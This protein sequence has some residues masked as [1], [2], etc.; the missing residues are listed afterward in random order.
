[1]KVSLI[2]KDKIVSIIL[3]LQIH[4]NYWIV[5][6]TKEGK[7]RNFINIV[8][9]G[10][11]WR[12]LSNYEINIYQNNEY[13]EYVDLT[14]NT[15]YLVKINGEEDALIYC[16]KVYEDR[17]AQLSLKHEADIII[18]SKENANICCNIPQILSEHA[19]LS[20]KN[21][22]WII[23]EINKDGYIYVNNVRVSNCKL[24]NGDII[25]IMGLK[26]IVIKNNIIINNIDKIKVDGNLFSEYRYQKQNVREAKETDELITLYKDSDYFFK[27]PRFRNNP[28]RIT[29]KVDSPP[30]KEKEE[31]TPIMYIIG[32]ML[33]MGMTSMVTAFTSINSVISNGRS[34]N[35]ALPSILIS[36]SMLMTMILWPILTRRY[37]K[38]ERKKK[39]KERRQKY[40][41]YIE[42][43][44]LEVRNAIAT[45][46]TA[47][48][49]SFP[50]LEEHK[51]TILFK[52]SNLWEKER[53]QEDFLRLRIGTGTEPAK[54]DISYPEEH[55][56]MDEDDLTGIINNLVSESKDLVNVPITV[57]FAE[58]YISALIGDS[59]VIEKIAKGLILQLITYHSYDDLKIVF[60][61]KEDKKE[62]WDFARVLPHCWNEDKTM[63]YYATNVDEMKQISSVLKNQFQSRMYKDGNG[64]IKNFDYKSYKPY[65]FIITDDFMNARD[66][67]IVKDVLSQKINVGFSLFILNDK[68]TNLPN[69][70]MNF[71]CI[72]H[73]NKSVIFEDELVTDKQKKFNVDIVEDLDLTECSIKLAN[74]PIDTINESNSFPK[75]LS[76]L[77]MYNVGNVEQLNSYNRWQVNAPINSLQAPVGVDRQGNIFKLDLHEKFHGPH[78]L[79]AGM[80]GSGKSEFIITYILSLAVNYHPNEVSFII[81]DYKGGGVALAFENKETGRKLPHIAGTIT[82]LDTV[83]MHRALV[84]IESELRRRQKAF[85]K[86]RDLSNESTI[87]IYKYQK[88]Y[89]EGIADEPISHLFII[90]DEFAELKDQ[91]PEFMEQLISTARIGR[92]LGVHL[93]LATQKPSGVVDDQI[94]SNSR[95]RICLKVQE[96]QDSMDMIKV[97]DA[98]MLKNVGR[99]YL[100]VGYNEFFAQGQSAWCGAPYIPT[101]KPKKKLDTSINLIDNIGYSIK[102]IDED[103]KTT[104]KNYGE[105]LANVMNY[106]ITVAKEE[107]I[108]V[109]QLW[110]D[111][112]PDLIYVDKLMAKYKYTSQKYIINPIIGEYDDP[113]NQRQDLLTLNLTENGN[114][115]IYGA[116]GSGKSTLI[117]SAIYSTIILHSAEEVNFYILDFGSE[118]FKIFNKAPQVGDVVLIN[119]IEKVHNLFKKL[120]SL[121]SQRK[122]LFVEYNGSFTYYNKK[123]LN[124]V[125]LIV[126]VINNYDAFFENYEN[127][128]EQL[129]QLTREGSKYGIVFLLTVNSVN[130]VKYRLRQNFKQELV[131]QMNDES[132]YYYVLG[133]TNKVYPSKV[134]GR[135]LVKYD[136]IY[137]FQTAYSYKPDEM[138]EYIRIICEKLKQNS[139]T[140]A[141]P[142]KILPEI[143]T[144]DTIN[145]K[146]RSLDMIPIGINKSTLDI[147]TWDFK[148]NYMTNITALDINN[149]NYFI[150]PF[151]SEFEEIKDATTIVIDALKMF[152]EPINAE[153][154][155]YYQDKFDVVINSLLTNVTKQHE[156]YIKNNYDRNVL[157][158]VKPVAIIILGIDSLL[159]KLNESAKNN[160]IKLVELG[161][162]TKT[163]SFILIDSIDFFKKIEYDNWYKGVSKNM[164]GI[165]IGNGIA[166]QYTLKIAKVTRELQDDIDRGFGYIVKRGIPT[167][168]KMLT[169]IYGYGSDNDG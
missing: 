3:P 88:L 11:S 55:F 36:V 120:N 98:A 6:K 28:D 164:Q 81:I 92:S 160:Y 44:R 64:N 63:R 111:R 50:P 104:E 31:K 100:Q 139:K 21:G 136:N 146:L 133:N 105:Q 10:N 62:Y 129:L 97:P 143:V 117:S 156:V 37:N 14:E 56:T 118:I 13:K 85:N 83:E 35:E 152:T 169:D 60:F 32:P 112:I 18:G 124:K 119:E 91:Q 46:T 67:E 131:L 89:R 115:I 19:R 71:I 57:S 49:E 16:G 53:D 142:I 78:G 148:N 58:K 128:E 134:Y 52:K 20:Y 59:P 74:I 158:K 166:N 1:M 163:I 42:N 159:M 47:L 22:S 101:D 138:S 162:I 149:M 99:F 135:G 39:E 66:I 140:F 87:D 108:E 96:K 54:I 168:T 123:S 26:L 45:Q 103:K 8:E 2:K 141:E 15:F 27:A 114:V 75:V 132:D 77:E 151:I 43:K 95:F 127:Y 17:T 157:S 29:I 116:S 38:K 41:A 65:Y 155:F 113:S 145:S 5:D 93:I 90:S 125:P 137:E 154:I 84:S 7:N 110:L 73:N 147:S 25:F 33:T 153:N 69:E 48:I 9:N 102:T 51:K 30:P 68:L 86:A 165:W 161:N 150:K 144:L 24:N 40:T 79:I 109:K 61:T 107:K 167:L 23:S 76:F 94:W 70:C 34:I 12:M 4:G 106:L 126:V 82:N 72:G 130:A 121:I 122:K 80:T